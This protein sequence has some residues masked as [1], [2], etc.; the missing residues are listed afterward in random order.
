MLKARDVMNK[1]II[2]IGP[3]QS[4]LDTMKLLY[5]RKSADCR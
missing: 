5:A 2:T 3:D 1:N 4:L